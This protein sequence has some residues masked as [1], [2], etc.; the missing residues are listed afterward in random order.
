M[1]GDV[2]DPVALERT[3]STT[4]SGAPASSTTPPDPV[5]MLNDLRAITREYLF[6]GTHSIPE[7]PGVP[8]GCV[9]YP[10]LDDD[11]REAFTRPH[12]GDL[13]GGWGVGTPSSRPRCSAT[14]TSG[15]G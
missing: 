5:Q 7:L 10:Y 9:F 15:G 12:W 1:Q 2:H 13:S 3:G 14:A 11:A 6:L 8:H 4:S